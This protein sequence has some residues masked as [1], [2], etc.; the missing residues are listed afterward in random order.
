MKKETYERIFQIIGSNKESARFWDVLGKL[1]TFCTGCCYFFTLLGR[2]ILSQWK[3]LG[4]L[5][6]VPA[7]SFGAVSVFRKLYDA[8]RPYELYGFQPLIQK[9]TRG[10]S[11]PSRHVFSIFVI[12]VSIAQFYP[13]AGISLGL[14]GV[15]LAVIRVITGVHFPKD[16]VAG[17]LIGIL[18]GGVANLIFFCYC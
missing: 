15:F 8:K 11:F 4:V 13:D 16:V 17:A 3:E 9:N 7:C 18:F 10:K 6:L 14:A 12:A 2:I 5:I 1:I